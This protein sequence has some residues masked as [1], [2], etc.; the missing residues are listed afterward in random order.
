MTNNNFIIYTSEQIKVEEKVKEILADLRLSI[1]YEY[2]SLKD[3]GVNEI[4]GALNTPTFLSDKKCLIIRNAEDIFNAS[5]KYYDYFIKY[6]ANPA[7]FSILIL[8][9]TD[10]KNDLFVDIKK[11][12]IYYDLDSKVESLDS[13]I[14]TYLAKN[15][16]TISKEAKELL[17]KYADDLNKIKNILDELVCYKIEEKEIKEEDISS[18]LEPPLEDNVYLLSNAVIKRDSLKAYEI[19]RDLMKSNVQIS[20][21][22]GLLISKFQEIYNNNI[23]IANGYTQSDLAEINNVKLGRAYYMLQEAKN[24]SSRSLKKTL[25]KLNDLEYGIK[26]GTL[27]PKV[28]FTSFLLSL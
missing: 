14:D 11:L 10:I 22:L 7:S 27:N 12:C 18:L 5:K 25:N 2:Y 6:L 9:F 16:F 24:V 1:D 20:Y 26:K 8:W 23:L 17:K 4:L 15:S 21:L 19:Y 28:A 13:Y 3:N